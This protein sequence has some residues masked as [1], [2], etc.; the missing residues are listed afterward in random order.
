[1]CLSDSYIIILLLN[2]DTVLITKLKMDSWDRFPRICA[3]CGRVVLLGYAPQ[4]RFVACRPVGQWEC[5]HQ[6]C[7][8]NAWLGPSPNNIGAP[9]IGVPRQWQ[10]FCWDFGPSLGG[11]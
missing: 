4:W 10:R 6:L 7:W 1:M 2:N 11:S 3:E 5:W 8:R 9:I